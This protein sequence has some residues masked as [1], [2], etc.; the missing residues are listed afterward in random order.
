MW[1]AD[2]NFHPGQEL[3]ELVWNI[4]PE[5]LPSQASSIIRHD[6]STQLFT[7]IYPRE[8]SS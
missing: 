4:L 2:E 8:F 1:I 6:V 3:E 7:S 5:I